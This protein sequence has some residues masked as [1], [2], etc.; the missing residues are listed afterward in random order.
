MPP[1]LALKLIDSDRVDV[2]E[3]P[4]H[5]SLGYPQ[6]NRK[7]EYKCLGSLI[8]DDIVITAAHC[9]SNRTDLPTIVK[10]GTV[11][12]FFSIFVIN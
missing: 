7:F 9:V 8:A 1:L 3:F 6:S 2:G 5:V 4:F 12:V 11:R 10:L